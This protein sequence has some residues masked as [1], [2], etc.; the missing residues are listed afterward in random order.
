MFPFIWGVI[1]IYLKL[2]SY[3]YTVLFLVTTESFA[4]C[5]HYRVMFFVI[6][7]NL[8][9]QILQLQSVLKI[10]PVW[11]RLLGESTKELYLN[12]KLLL[13]RR[14]DST[15]ISGQVTASVVLIWTSGR[16]LSFATKMIYRIES[17]SS[18]KRVVTFC[19]SPRRF[20]FFFCTRG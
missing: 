18:W 1:F 12:R 19:T 17:L 9:R 13:F 2:Q 20:F 11:C 16:I 7:Q 14:S 3:G 8:F 6:G 5:L 15:N 4:R 10:E